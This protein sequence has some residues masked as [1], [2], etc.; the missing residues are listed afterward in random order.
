MSH[1]FLRLAEMALKRADFG[2][3]L[4]WLQCALTA[5][6]RG[7][8]VQLCVIIFEAQTATLNALLASQKRS[9]VL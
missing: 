7:G 4:H 9:G 5:A 6:Q 3:A 2:V 8:N 1:H